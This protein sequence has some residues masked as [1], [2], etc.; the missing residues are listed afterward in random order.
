MLCIFIERNVKDLGA[1]LKLN[2]NY[3]NQTLHTY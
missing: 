3:E 2:T 1:V